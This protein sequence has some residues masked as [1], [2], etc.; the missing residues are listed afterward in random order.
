M[1]KKKIDLSKEAEAANGEDEVVLITEALLLDVC[2]KE[3]TAAFK[4]TK[5]LASRADF[6][7]TFEKAQL[8]EARD[9]FK[10][11]DNFANKLEAWF[12]QELTADMTGVTG[13]IGRVETKTKEVAIVEDW[14]AFYA[15]L[16]KKGEFDLMNKALNQKAIKERWEAGRN[17][18]GVGK[19]TKKVIS[20]TGVKGKK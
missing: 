4:K 8:K 14:T 3:M 13:K 6:L 20:L 12:I 10:A 5:N 17:V 9:R 7:Y 16:K 2:P 19:F 15:N 18:P 1:A 11:L